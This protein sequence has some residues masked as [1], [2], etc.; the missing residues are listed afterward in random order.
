MLEEKT[1]DAM[2]TFKETDAI[3][4]Q[5]TSDIQ[6]STNDDSQKGSQISNLQ[7]DLEDLRRKL[8]SSDRE[9][10]YQKIIKEIFKKNNLILKQNVLQMIKL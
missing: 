7:G 1:E 6:Q 5:L 4:K 8:D 3:L 9:K 10:K 2:K